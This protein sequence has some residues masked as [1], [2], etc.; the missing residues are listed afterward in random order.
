MVMKGDGR[1]PPCCRPFWCQ[2]GL[3]VAARAEKRRAE[4]ASRR[5]ATAA[6]GGVSARSLFRHLLPAELVH[7][8]PKGARFWSLM[9]L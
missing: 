3:V 1:P 8:G 2:A 9:R 6:T 4:F 5:R 7:L